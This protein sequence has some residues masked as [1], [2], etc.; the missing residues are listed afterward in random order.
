MISETSEIIFFE[1]TFPKKLVEDSKSI[2]SLEDNIMNRSGLSNGERA[3]I[4]WDHHRD[5]VAIRSTRF[6]VFSKDSSEFAHE[7][8]IFHSR[9]CRGE[10]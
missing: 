6:A 7:Y 8:N 9:L 2:T 4:E 5:D 10:V 3:L 1:I